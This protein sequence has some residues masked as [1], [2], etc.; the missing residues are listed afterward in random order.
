MNPIAI[1]RYILVEEHPVKVTEEE[2]DAWKKL[3]PNP[4][5]IRSTTIKNLMRSQ[6]NSSV[7]Q[8][9]K[10]RI[11]TRFLE[12]DDDFPQEFNPKPKIYGT[13]SE[14]VLFHT[15]STLKEAIWIHE[16]VVNRLKKIIQQ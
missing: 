3:N 13:E 12:Y 1:H 14:G 2:Y 6:T 7:S 11:V 15:S 10:I 9:E 5:W 8:I 16:R 4:I